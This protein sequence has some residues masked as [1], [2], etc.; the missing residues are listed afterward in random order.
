MSLIKFQPKVNSEVPSI[1]DEFF[2]RDLFDSSNARVAGN[3]MPAV[4]IK[5]D[6]DGFTL[7]IAAPGFNKNDF[8]VNVDKQIL[9]VSSESTSNEEEVKGGYTRKEFNYSSFKRS[10]T[11]PESADDDSIKAQYKEGILSIEISKR[12]EAKAKPSRIIKIK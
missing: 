10:F 5:E 9:T 1:W 8:T 2:S 7:E 12:E 11:L 4:N 6:D 3:T